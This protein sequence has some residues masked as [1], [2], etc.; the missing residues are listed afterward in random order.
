MLQNAVCVYIVTVMKVDVEVIFRVTDSQAKVAVAEADSGRNGSV[1]NGTNVSGGNR[2]FRCS[3]FA[4]FR[5]TL[6][7]FLHRPAARAVA[8]RPDEAAIA[9]DLLKLFS[10]PLAAILPFDAPLSPWKQVG[11][12]PQFVVHRN[13]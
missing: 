6:C 10:W 13:H 7:Q 8:L 2:P 12:Q 11:T 5:K 1:G 9:A 4:V 3:P